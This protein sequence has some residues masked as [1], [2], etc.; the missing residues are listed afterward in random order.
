[1]TFQRT[2]T[3]MPFIM[4]TCRM[5]DD[6]QSGSIHR[7]KMY[8]PVTSTLLEHA[9]STTPDLARVFVE[10]G[11]GTGYFSMLASSWRADVVGFEPNATS[12]VMLQ[13][14]AGL[15]RDGRLRIVPYAVG[16]KT[17]LAAI[18]G[19]G[20]ASNSTAPGTNGTTSAAHNNTSSSSI[21]SN[22]NNTSNSTSTSSSSGSPKTK[23][24]VDVVKLSDAISGDV[25]LTVLLINAGTLDGVSV[26]DLAAAAEGAHDMLK[27]VQVRLM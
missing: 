18:V 2:K 24:G 9:L 22:S 21:T 10:V 15:H 5:C 8:D 11:P 3:A 4:M 16:A 7:I 13:H 1:M 17:T 14:N 23:W 12:R 27:R 25:E 26:P 20:A 6:P 19:D